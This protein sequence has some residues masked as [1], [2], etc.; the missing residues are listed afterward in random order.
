LGSSPAEATVELIVAGK[1]F[2][3]V[4]ALVAVSGGRPVPDAKAI[5]HVPTQ[6]FMEP[7]VSA[8]PL[9]DSQRIVGALKAAGGNV[10]FTIY[11]KAG[12]DAC[13]ETDINLD[14]YQWLLRQRRRG[15]QADQ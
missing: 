10:I 11:P 13:S 5:G 9:N 7:K 14:L 3:F 15:E 1:E 12:H 6:I 2:L 8:I 4:A